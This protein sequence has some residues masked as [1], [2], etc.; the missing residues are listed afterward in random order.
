M[1]QV[2]YINAVEEV[3]FESLTQKICESDI[4]KQT[5]AIFCL[6]FKNYI[7]S[8][9]ARFQEVSLYVFDSLAIFVT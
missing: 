9:F 1:H 4:K 6:L 3:S 7:N 2:T 8:Q 5:I